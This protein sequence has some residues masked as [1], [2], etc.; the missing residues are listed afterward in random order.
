MPFG[1]IACIVFTMVILIARPYRRKGDDRLHLFVQTE[2]FL[3]LYCG[4]AF[5]N[6][7]FDKDAKRRQAFDIAMSLILIFG[8]LALFLLFS[9][10]GSCSTQL[11]KIAWL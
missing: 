9:V 2:I 5:Q 7:P 1:L 3:M 6:Q 8:A 4:F 11:F 10:Q